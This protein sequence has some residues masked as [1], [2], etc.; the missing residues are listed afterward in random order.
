ML[1]KYNRFCRS[2][3]VKNTL[4]LETC[5]WIIKESEKINNWHSP[6]FPHCVKNIDLEFLPHVL[7]YILSTLDT[8][9]KIIKVVYNINDDINI[10]NIDK[11]YVSKYENNNINKN[12][13]KNN[14]FLT[15]NILLNEFIII[16]DKF[17]KKTHVLN[18]GDMLIYYQNNTFSRSN[19]NEVYF[20]VFIL[21]FNLEELNYCNNLHK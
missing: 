11:M 8:F 6:I 16:D 5:Q 19:S 7:T 9:I 18:Q 17:E 21:D 14:S 12:K 13:I 10:F 2:N 4:S 1:K 20:L 15:I 3:I